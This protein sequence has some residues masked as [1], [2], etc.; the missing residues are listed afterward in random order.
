MV[1]NVNNR[2]YLIAFVYLEFLK[3]SRPQMVNVQVPVPVQ[4]CPVP[5]P[6]PQPVPVQVWSHSF[7]FPL[8]YA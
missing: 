7:F 6:V 5:V 1:W 2:F 8:I 3:K 4:Q